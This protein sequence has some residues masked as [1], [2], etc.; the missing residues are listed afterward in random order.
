MKKIDVFD[1]ANEILKGVKSGALVTTKAGDKVNTMAISWGTL[2][3]EWNKPIF[4]TF[5]RENRFT[6]FQLEKHEE[7]TINIPLGEFDKKIIGVAGTKS[8]FNVDKIAEL[9]LT[10]VDGMEIDVPG[11]KELPL[12]LECKVVYKQMQD[13]SAISEEN[14]LVH[15]PEDVDSSYH[16]ANKDYH[17]AYYGEIV[18]AYIIE[19]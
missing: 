12:T 14:R 1:Y 11:I 13:S 5:V 8:G 16:S 19:D 18:S 4:I 3:I 15:Y 6:K 17:I 10:L 9:G 7:F 2:G